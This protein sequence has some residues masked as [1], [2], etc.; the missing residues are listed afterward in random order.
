MLPKLFAVL[1][2][3][4]SVSSVARGDDAKASR[5]FTD[6]IGTLPE[7]DRGSSQNCS[8]SA[9]SNHAAVYLRRND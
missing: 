4:L 5:V 6:Y 8:E 2:V 7:K 3:V 9:G 1:V